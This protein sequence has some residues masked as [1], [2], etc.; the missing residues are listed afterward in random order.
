MT[1]NQNPEGETPEESM[2][3]LQGEEGSGPAGWGGNT[4]PPPP[5]SSPY[6]NMN[7]ADSTPPPP[8]IPDASYGQPYGQAYGQQPYGQQYG[9][10]GGM[11]MSQAK[12]DHPQTVTILVMGIISVICCS[13]LGPVVWWMGNNA[14]KESQTNPGLNENN[15][16]LT[17]GWVLGI[18]GTA[19]LVLGILFYA[20]GITGSLLQG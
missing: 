13:F 8:P 9:A 4:P 17:I 3:R 5:P 20:M 12:Q 7:G 18:V 1:E 16:T 19:L 15:T 14:R 11:G 6:G 10:P 2:R